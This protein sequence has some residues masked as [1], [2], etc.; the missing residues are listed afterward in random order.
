MKFSF[1][2]LGLAAA[3]AACSAKDQNP[4][5]Y[6]TVS[7]FCEGW[8]KAACNATVVKSCAGVDTE[9]KEL[10]QGCLASQQTFCEGLV[11][12]VGYSSQQA[13][14]CLDAVRSAYADGKLSADDVAIV[15]HRGDPCNHLIKGPKDKNEDCTTDDDCDTLNNYVCVM[16]GASG[17]CEIPT[18]VDNGDSCKARD[19]EC[20]PGHYCDSGS[21][22]VESA[23]VGDSCTDTYECLSSLDCDADTQ[24][25]ALR[26][27]PAKCKEDGDCVTGVC[28]IAAGSSTGKCVS[29]IT[30][31]Q[32]DSLCGD[33]AQ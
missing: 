20:N 10:T 30:L 24:Q 11:P 21:H 28:D 19:A 33:L 6:G 26:V 16:K 8:A 32:T 5:P 9:T 3:L 1:I 2:C 29:Q 12:S 27:N 7:G 4:D 25:C 14:V 18:V 22:C 23:G 13:S 15:R 17:S 31:T